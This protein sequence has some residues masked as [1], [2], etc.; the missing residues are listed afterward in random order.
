[1][2]MNGVRTRSP[3]HTPA[4]ASRRIWRHSRW[5]LAAA[6]L[7]L[8]LWA[9][10]GHPL[11][12]PKPL[13]E[14]QT[15]LRYE[16]NPVRKLD[17]IFMIDNSSSMT[18]KQDN[19]RKNFPSFMNKL[20]AI[21]GGAPDMHIAVIS[22]NVGAGPTVPDPACNVTGDRGRFQVR[23]ECG[24][25]T[26]STGYFLTIDSAGKTNFEDKGG[27]PKLPELFQCMAFLGD[28]GCGYEHPLLSLY[29]ALDGKTNP[30][31]A[32]F[33]RD[34]AYLGVV[35]LTDEDDCSGEPTADFFADPPAPGVSGSVRCSFKG[36]TCNGQPVG[37]MPGFSAPLSACAPYMR[38]DVTEKNSR[39]INVQFFVDFLKGLKQGRTDKIL[40]SE[41]IGWSDAADAT[42]SIALRPQ[43]NGSL[44]LDTGPICADMGAGA[45]TPGL[46]LHAFA[47]AFPNHTVFPICQTDLSPA[48][49]EIASRLITLLENTCIQDPLFDIDG[50]KTNGVQ[51]DCQVDDLV[52]VDNGTGLYKAQTLPACSLNKGMPCWDLDPDPTCGGGYRTKVTRTTPAAPGTLQSIKCLT[53]P[54]GHTENCTR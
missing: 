43:K 25:N 20:L 42:Y 35:M 46:R 38:D 37:Q 7:P 18:D 45:A 31:N 3:A 16:V 13:P 4:S 49:D 1:M 28:K 19:L 27:L 24:I 51:P 44:A 47:N 21:E 22:S 8:A 15:D 26:A 11:E 23:P 41:V 32:G 5:I 48:M 9:C 54:M 6:A 17:L 10:T 52:P 33:L 2:R 12:Q 39:L 34:D 40:V 14:Q 30:E 29:F 36:H 50:D 53:C